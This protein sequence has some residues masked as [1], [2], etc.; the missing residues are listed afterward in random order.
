MLVSQAKISQR[1]RRVCQ[2]KIIYLD[3][4][5]FLKTKKKQTKERETETRQ[6]G[7]SGVQPDTDFPNLTKSHRTSFSSLAQ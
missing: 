7:R 6:S 1:A 2:E 3:N 5:A 4:P